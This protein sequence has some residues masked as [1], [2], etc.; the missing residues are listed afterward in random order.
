MRTGKGHSSSALP[1]KNLMESPGEAE[2]MGK[3]KE[4]YRLEHEYRKRLTGDNDDFERRWEAISKS[5]AFTQNAYPNDPILVQ[6]TEAG[7]VSGLSN[8]FILLK[9]RLDEPTG[10]LEQEF[11]ET[12]RK[13]K[14]LCPKP[15]RKHRYDGVRI[16]ELHRYL[17]VYDLRQKGKTWR[18]IAQQLK[19]RES[20]SPGP[21]DGSVK[22]ALQRDYKNAEVI[23]MNLVRDPS[24]FPTYPDLLA[25]KI[26]IKRKK[27]IR[28]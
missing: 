3:E 18:E 16:D 9:I 11:K 17:K 8:G 23:L 4:F 1:L 24:S 12:I 7:E 2:K 21:L 27:Q 10:T 6:H 20:N 28:P 15:K 5:R 13:A 26:P 22:R 25:R 14:A 19:M